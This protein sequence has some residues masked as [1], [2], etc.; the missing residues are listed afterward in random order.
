M[1]AGERIDVKRNR[2]R[3]LETA[4]EL[5]AASGVDVSTREIARNAGVGVATLYRHFPT[6]D[7]LVDA[8]LED[9]FDELMT[10]GT[11]AM[12]REDAWIGFTELVD[13]ALALGA[14]N[15]GFKEAFETQRGRRKAAAMRRSIRPVFARLVEKAQAQGSLRNDFTPQDVPM[16]FWSISAVAEL[17]AEVSPDLWRRQLGF[18]IDGLRASAATR[19]TQSALSEVQLGRIEQAGARKLERTP[20]PHGRDLGKT[21]ATVEVSLGRGGDGSFTSGG[22]DPGV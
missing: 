17:A 5:F 12:S 9:A 11:R 22:L 14:R 10:A 6:R 18:V 2:G 3:L 15:R 4:R 8:V 16:L 21:R 20:I 7:D 1:V 13:D 19:Q